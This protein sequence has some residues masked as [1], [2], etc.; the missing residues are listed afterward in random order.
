[1]MPAVRNGPA[2]AALHAMGRL[3]SKGVPDLRWRPV[4]TTDHQG[5]ASRVVEALQPSSGAISLN[6]GD[7]CPRE[8]VAQNVNGLP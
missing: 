5:V 2:G 1:M 7:T 3:V 6:H 8:S 4:R